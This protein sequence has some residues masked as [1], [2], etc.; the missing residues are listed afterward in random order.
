MNAFVFTRVTCD[1]L[2][3]GARTLSEPVIEDVSDTAL[4]VAT[5]RAEESRRKDA[6]F[7]DPLADRLAGE[8]GR[9]L[10]H[11]MKDLAVVG[12]SVVLR[13]VIIDAYVHDCI[14]GG[15]DTVLNLGAGLDTRPYRMEL[16]P[17]LRWV[18]VDY[19]HVL[20]LKEERLAGETPCC[21]LERVAVDLTQRDARR[22]LFARVASQARKVLVLTEGVVPYLSVEDVASL[23]EDLHAQERFDAWVVDVM[24]QLFLEWR[25][26]NPRFQ[27]HL[28]NAPFRFTPP[29]WQAFYAERGWGVRQVRYQGEEAVRL[30]RP[31]PVPFYQRLLARLAP[32]EVQQRWQRMSGFALLERR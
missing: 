32:R 25:T 21:Q 5:Y 11:R 18:E 19:P 26:K 31:P 16:P 2:T 14:A 12:W 20:R 27:R 1:A 29:D 28:A 6:L 22:A 7:R 23:A 9:A 4:W 15:V 30:R 13:T 3:E 17:T 24:S 10:A 8:R